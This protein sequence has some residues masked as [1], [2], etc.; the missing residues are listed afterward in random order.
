MSEFV[1]ENAAD[2]PAPPAP[3]PKSP[4]PPSSAPARAMRLQR[5]YARLQEG[6]SVGEIAKAERLSYER[7]RQILVAARASHRSEDKPDHARMQ[8]AR[9]APVL[10]QTVRAATLGDKGATRDLIAVIDRLDRYCGTAAS[11][12]AI[13]FDEL[14]EGDARTNA[15]T[16]RDRILSRRGAALDDLMAAARAQIRAKAAERGIEDDGAEDSLDDDD[17]DN[18]DDDID[19]D[20]SDEPDTEGDDDNDEDEQNEEED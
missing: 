16:D 14:G 11:Y 4:R 8:I 15:V 7:V 10:R 17:D 12:R 3:K 9:L 6:F 13:A 18:D 1:P 2:R 5:I 20:D 19:L